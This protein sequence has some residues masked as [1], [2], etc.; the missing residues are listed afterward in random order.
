MEFGVL[1]NGYIY[2]QRLTHDA[3]N[4]RLFFSFLE[5]H[6]AVTIVN[7]RLELNL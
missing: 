6:D 7:I 1:F 3:D 5:T 4:G 2:L